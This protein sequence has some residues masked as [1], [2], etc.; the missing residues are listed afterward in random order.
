MEKPGVSADKLADDFIELSD[1]LS[2]ARTFYP[3]SGTEQYL[4]RLMARFQSHLYKHRSRRKKGV[5]EFWKTDFPLLIYRERRTLLFAVLFFVAACLLGW[6]SAGRDGNFLR[7]ILGD[8]YVNMTIDN[9]E[10]GTP[11]GV[12]ASSD[13]WEM[14]WRITINNVRVSLIAF[15]FG[16]LF[17]AGTLWV[18]LQNGVMLGAFQYFFYDRGILLHS[19]LSVWAHG[20]FEITAIVIAGGAGLIMGNS[21]LF[22]GTYTRT[23]SFMAGALKGIKIV[24]GLIPFF[25]VAGAIESYVTRYADSHPWVGLIAILLSLSGIIAYFVWYPHLVNLKYYGENR[26]EPET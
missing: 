17:S 21:F 25:I 22:P 26:T 24:A 15:V 5:I 13:A 2:Y 12:Y 7:L 4:N 10:K 23:D 3:G 16:I 9:I 6:F 19:A 1:D 20:T 8:A 18:L 14:F 11:M